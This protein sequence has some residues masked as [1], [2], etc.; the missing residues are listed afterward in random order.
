MNMVAQLPYFFQET[1]SNKPRT[2]DIYT[3]ISTTLPPA[4]KRGIPKCDPY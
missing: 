2:T 1:S 4:N 3:R